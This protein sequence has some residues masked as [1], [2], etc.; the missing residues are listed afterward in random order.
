MTTKTG[1]SIRVSYIISTKDRAR[2]LAE[3]LCNVREFIT[4]ADELII[5]DG[6]STDDTAKV[7]ETNRDIVTLFISEPDKGEAHGFNKGILASRGQFIKGLTDDD[8]IYPEAMRDA[9]ALM[10]TH[11]EVD[12]LMCGGETFTWDETKGQMRLHYLHYMQPG[13]RV[14]D[15][16]E[17][18]IYTVGCGVG[19]LLR[20]GVIAQVGLLDTTFHCVDLDIIER[21]IRCKTN[22]RFANLKLYRHFFHPHSGSNV[23]RAVACDHLRVLLRS[24]RWEAVG[25]YHWHNLG[26]VLGLLDLPRGDSLSKLIIYGERLRRSPFRALLRWATRALWLPYRIA[27]WVSKRPVLYPNS[28]GREG[29]EPVEFDG[30]LH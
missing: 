9:I 24:R 6:G 5:V 13:T 28:R 18:T 14:T 29:D 12:A 4:P 2:Y 27:A 23:E 10:E 17:K 7:V 8:H 15:A 20:R 30:T 11:P 19:L 1:D 22:F 21:L 3:A 26:D 25:Y 16:L